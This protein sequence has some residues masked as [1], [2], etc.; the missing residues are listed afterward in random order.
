MQKPNR[1]L[2]N[3]RLL[4]LLLAAIITIALWQLP[5]GNFILYPFTILAT[6]FHELG[7]GLSA[8]MLGGHLEGLSI[9]RNGSGLAHIRGPIALGPFGS[10]LV[11][12]GGLMGPPIAGAILL[13]ASRSHQSAKKALFTLGVLLILSTLLWVR[14]LIGWLILP[15]LGA[16]VLY[17][18]LESIQWLQVLAVQFLGVQACVSSYRQIDYFFSPSATINGKTLTSDTG[19]ISEMLLLPHWFWGA[20]LTALTFLILAESLELACKQ[21]PTI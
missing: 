17:L 3:S 5:F 2:A 14:T 18:S 8:I 16:V 7:H 19:N 9:F 4:W 11:S 13:I 10:A 21:K 15:L 20:L 6:W 1:L 12:A